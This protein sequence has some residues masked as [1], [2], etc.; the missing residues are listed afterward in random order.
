MTVFVDTGVVYAEQDHSA[1]RHDVAAAALE[2]VQDGAFGQP[3]VSD[4]VYD[5]AVMLT[6]QRSG[7]HERAVH[8]GKRIR[9]DGYP[10]EF[11]MLDVE[12]PQFDEAVEI[13]ERYDDQRLSF[14]DATTVALVRSHDIDHVLAFD[15]DFD[16][17]VDRLAPAT[18]AERNP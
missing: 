9:G 10:S 18:V 16:G 4:Y 6:L 5:E 7:D 1:S 3:Y 15:D 12:S 13:F 17:L 11:S 14:T 2:A 8:V